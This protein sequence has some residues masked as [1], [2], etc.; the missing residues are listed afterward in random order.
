MEPI[1]KAVG[2]V[3]I[4]VGWFG[5]LSDSGLGVC[6]TNQPNY[7]SPRDFIK[8]DKEEASESQMLNG[9]NIDKND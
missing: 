5:H 4:E 1:Q 2:L 3:L 9:E 8:E 7:S 6:P